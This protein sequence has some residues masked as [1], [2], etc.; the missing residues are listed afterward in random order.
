MSQQDNLDA[1]EK[2]A[3]DYALALDDFNAKQE[4]YKKDSASY[5]LYQQRLANL[6][7]HTGEYAPIFNAY[8]QDFKTWSMGTT[9]CVERFYPPRNDWCANDVQAAIT[10]W[11]N[12]P[13][14][15]AAGYWEDTNTDNVVNRIAQGANWNLVTENAPNSYGSSASC[16]FPLTSHR[17]RCKIND[18][19]TL[20]MADAKLKYHHTPTTD[21]VTSQNW[22]VLGP[23]VAPIPGPSLNIQCCGMVF[24]DISADKIDFDNIR[25]NCTQNI[26]TNTTDSSTGEKKTDVK[27]S[28]IDSTP[29]TSTTMYI[30]IG[31][32]VLLLL[33]CSSSISGVIAYYR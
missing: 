28:T 11:G 15:P 22:A 5:S 10:A 19:F 14:F 1:C 21:G 32:I 26:T 12:P 9:N 13:Y 20:L 7:A 23:P 30:I 24:K 4:Q 29:E 2:A 31:I 27:T 33:C 17:R 8:V 25:Q 3:E 18:N 16:P 6:N